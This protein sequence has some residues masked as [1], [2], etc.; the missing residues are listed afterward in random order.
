M[1]YGVTP[2]QATSP[3]PA[4]ATLP[5][6][7]PFTTQ[8]AQIATGTLTNIAAS[9]VVKV[10]NT[11]VI[12]QTTCNV[13]QTT[14]THTITKGCSVTSTK[15]VHA[16]TLYA[17][18]GIK[19]GNVLIAQVSAQGGDTGR[20]HGADRLDEGDKCIGHRPRN[21][22]HGRL[23]LRRHKGDRVQDLPGLVDLEVVDSGDKGGRHL[24]LHHAVHQRHS[25]K[26]HRHGGHQLRQHERVDDGHIAQRHPDPGRRPG[27]R[28]DL[29]WRRPALHNH[30]VQADSDHNVA[31]L[32]RPPRQTQPSSTARSTR[33]SPTRSV[34]AKTVQAG[35]AATGKITY[36]QTTGANNKFAWNSATIALRWG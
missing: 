28:A 2:H 26:P 30:D 32:R 5:K 19:A 13:T 22:L 9:P 17:P 21:D 35:V 4:V 31:L 29:E 1:T 27:D 6:T 36:T 10:K 24:R 20:A 34:L 7:Y 8:G 11:A 12:A 18:S 23:L 16:I 14:N 33:S 25:D 3:N 15:Q